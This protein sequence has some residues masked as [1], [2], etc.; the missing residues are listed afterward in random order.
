MKANMFIE[1][2]AKRQRSLKVEHDADDD[3]DDKTRLDNYKIDKG[4][5]INQWPSFEF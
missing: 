5:W 2:R 1:L 3:D 4:D